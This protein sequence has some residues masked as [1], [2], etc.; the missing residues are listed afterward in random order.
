MG[1]VYIVD[2]GNNCV[3]KVTVSTDIISTIAG[4]CSTTTGFSGDGL[5]ATAASLNSP[6]GI[7]VD[8]SGKSS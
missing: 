2:F 7:A 1:N 4:S 6:Q 8:L 3:R 5:A